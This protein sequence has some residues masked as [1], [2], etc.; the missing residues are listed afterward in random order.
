MGR[1]HRWRERY[2]PD[3]RES[4]RSPRKSS[5]SSLTAASSAT[6]APVHRDER[7]QATLDPAPPAL[8]RREMADPD[9]EARRALPML[10]DQ[11]RM[12]CT[13]K[14]VV[15]GRFPRWL[16]PPPHR[17]GRLDQAGRCTLSCSRPR[18]SDLRPL[19][20]EH[21]SDEPPPGGCPRRIVATSVV[22]PAAHGTATLGQ[23]AASN[24]APASSPPRRR[25]TSRPPP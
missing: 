23:R 11:R 12:V 6:A 25:R 14:A 7:E 3:R 22:A 16:R 24:R 21:A 17:G 18:G 15:R 5:C 19:G 9:R 8:P 10:N 1:A 2:G 13:P 4:F 20:P